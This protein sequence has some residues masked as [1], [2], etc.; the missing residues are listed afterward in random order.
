MPGVAGGV[1]GVLPEAGGPEVAGAA[2]GVEVRGVAPLPVQVVEAVPRERVKPVAFVSPLEGPRGLPLV[3][4]GI[5]V[6]LGALWM[7]AR[8]QRRNKR[9]K[10]W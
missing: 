10:V 5:G 1:Q 6:L 8:R 4:G 9:Q 3:A 7:V 2:P